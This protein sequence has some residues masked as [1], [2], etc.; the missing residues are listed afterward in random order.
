MVFDIAKIEFDSAINIDSV[1]FGIM[2]KLIIQAHKKGGII[3]LSWHTYNPINNQSSW[4]SISNVSQI[5]KDGALKPKY[6]EWVKKVAIFIKSLK[7]KGKRI[8]VIFRPYHEM[9][10]SWFWWGGKNCLP[11]DYIT[12]WQ[13]TVHMLR[14]EY[15]VH[16][17]L[18]AY[19]PNKLNA[20]DDYLKYYPGDDYVDIFGIDIY[21]FK[22]SED[23]IKSLKN[24]LSLVKAIANEKSKLYAFTETGLES[25]PTDNWFTEVLYPNIKDSGIAW[26][27]FWRNANKTHHYMP[28]KFHTNEA[29]FIKFQ[30]MKKTLFLGDLKKLKL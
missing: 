12:L 2:R 20:N 9:N 15:K 13:E 7:Y 18:Y 10:G 21:D 27:L 11:K 25:I 5:I 26:I 4:D 14:D 22:D 17:I 6:K 30:K 28:Y 23:Y 24:D 1:D 8:P 3:T 19:S 29:D 16:N